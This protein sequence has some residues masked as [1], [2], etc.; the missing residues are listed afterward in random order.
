MFALVSIAILIC[1]FFIDITS[2][3][4]ARAAT[5]GT[6]LG[7]GLIWLIVSLIKDFLKDCKER[8]QRLQEF[9]RRCKESAEQRAHWEEQKKKY[10]EQKLRMKEI[11][12]RYPRIVIPYR[13]L[14]I[15]SKMTDEE[16]AEHAK[17]RF[18]SVF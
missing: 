14:C 13:T 7:I 8:K 15:L 12:E 17:K 4:F 10:E 9:D 16:I 11:Q 1:C 5:A 18:R 6:F 3:N 2:G